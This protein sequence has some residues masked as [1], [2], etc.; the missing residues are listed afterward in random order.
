MQ[1]NL[2]Y[3]GHAFASLAEA[4]EPASNV[5]YGAQF[6][7]HLR[8]ETRSGRVRPRAIT[9]RDPD[10]GQAYRD[11]V[12]RLWQEVATVGWPTR[13]GPARRQTAERGHHDREGRRPPVPTG[14]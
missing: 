9:S 10:R 14:A 4:L 6:L 13:A 11:K 5:A 8:H 1:V 3:H 2:G 7:K 12:Y